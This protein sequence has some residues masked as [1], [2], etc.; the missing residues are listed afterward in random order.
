M[1]FLN[2]GNMDLKAFLDDSIRETFYRLYF[3]YCML[4]V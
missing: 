1:L 2:P 3:I 4:C